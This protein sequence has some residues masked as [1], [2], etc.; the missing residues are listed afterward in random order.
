MSNSAEDHAL[1]LM[2]ELEAGN[3]S[4]HPEDVVI[5]ASFGL[6]YEAVNVFV[7]HCQ[8]DKMTLPADELYRKMEAASD[9]PRPMIHG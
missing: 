4:V 5:Y 1:K 7:A 8:D 2:R 6:G 9:T 3:K